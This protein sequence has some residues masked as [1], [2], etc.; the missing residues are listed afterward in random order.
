MEKELSLAYG[1]NRLKGL[2]E[3]NSFDNVD[4]STGKEDLTH[5]PMTGVLVK[6]LHE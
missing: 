1:V 6:I 2:P 4:V 3:M 5:N